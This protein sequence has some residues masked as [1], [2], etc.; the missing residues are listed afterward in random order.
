MPFWPT[1]D[2]RPS[3]LDLFERHGALVFRRCRQLLGSDDAAHDA[4]QE[5][6]LRVVQKRQGFRGESAWSTWLYGLAT[7][8]CLQQLRNARR[9]GTEPV[10]DVPETSYTPSL[11]EKLSLD[12]LLAM[13]DDEVRTM[14]VLRH[15]EQLEVEEIARTLG[16][17]RKT[18][19]RKLQRFTEH[20]HAALSEGESR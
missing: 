7:L 8:H 2:R 13:E 12:A 20:A 11:D 16:C 19:T 14:V 10:A 5:V 9:R 1:A 15:V 18:V 3:P 6:F 4:T 17:S